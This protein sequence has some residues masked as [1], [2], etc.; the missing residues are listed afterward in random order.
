VTLE[1]QAREPVVSVQLK[2]DEP[3]IRRPRVL[4]ASEQL[5]G[6]PIQVSSPW[7]G[8]VVG[9]VPTVGRAATEAAIDAAHAA[10][11]AGLPAFRRAEILD[12]AS[13][14]I[15]AR[16]EEFA[17]ILALEIG[18]PFTQAL[19]EVDRCVQTL[20]FSAVEA[21]TLTGTGVAFDA[22][23]AGVGHRGFTIRV[24]IGVVGAIA[25]FNFPL[26]LAAHKIGPAIAT[27]CGVVVKP[28]REAPL[29]VAELAN[30]LY[31][32]GLP[33][34]W[35]SV[36]VG[37]AGEIADALVDDARVGMITFTGSSEVGWDLAR[38]A[39]KKRVKLELGN[40]TPLIVC[41]DG[42]LDKAAAVVAASGFGFAGQSCISV[43][44]V[45]VEE[46]VHDAFVDALARETRA[47]KVGDPLDSDTHVG[48]LIN[49]EARD[50]VNE[51]IAEAEDGGARSVVA[52]GGAGGHLGPVVLD[53]IT[54]DV[55]AWAQE[56]FGPVVG[57]HRFTTFDEAIDLANSTEF[58]LQAGV[59]TSDIS[60][61][62]DA[63]ERLEFGGV[64]INETP[65][66]RVDQ[67]PYGGTKE[68]GNTR[69]GPHYTVAEMT[70][71]RVVVIGE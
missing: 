41:A 71:E 54:P 1:R 5:S 43:Q 40:S 32:A 45:I 21:R 62:L 60:K 51:W 30:V 6:D 56:V 9:E 63:S 67:M 59:Y 26:N 13:D 2:E 48:P 66:F 14:G 64:T 39:P 11:Q 25:P 36:V 70:E 31:D 50:R 27:G 53:D 44:R 16:R 23:P 68:S 55:R 37:P 58:G 10:M 19:V 24:P 46:S 47:K 52:A 65:T 69:E 42:N 22:H 49:A 57:V 34:E 28:S 12:A 38:R 4:V 20:K 61:A 29:A 33:S 15:R 17:R 8:K 3:T 35:L 7:D 18:K